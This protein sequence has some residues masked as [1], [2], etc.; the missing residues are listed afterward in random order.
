MSGTVNSE[1]TAVAPSSSVTPG[2]RMNCGA[3]SGLPGPLPL[4]PASVLLPLL[5]LLLSVVQM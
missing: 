4:L 5:P 3:G 1:A 2:G